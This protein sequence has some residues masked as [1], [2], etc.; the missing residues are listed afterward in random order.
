MALTF[1]L[2]GKIPLLKVQAP[3]ELSLAKDKSED[4]PLQLRAQA[5]QERN[6]TKLQDLPS[7][8]RFRLCRLNDPHPVYAEKRVDMTKAITG[9]SSLMQDPDSFRYQCAGRRSSI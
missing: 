1:Y 3:Q 7:E 4:P 9:G 5:P 8:F 6:V 2:M